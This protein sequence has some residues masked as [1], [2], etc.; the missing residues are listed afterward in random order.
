MRVKAQIKG[1][2]GKR[3]LKEKGKIKSK[4]ILY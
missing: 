3:G 2:V 4:K 1:L